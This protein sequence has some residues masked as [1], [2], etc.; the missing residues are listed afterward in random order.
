MLRRERGATAVLVAGSLFLLM[1]IAAIAIDYSAALNERRQDVGAAD[2]AAIGGLLEAAITTAAN[3][4]QVAV[5]EAKQIAN[6]NTPGTITN[7][8]WSACTDAEALVNPSTLGSLG[9]VNGTPCISFSADFTTMRVRIP[10]QDVPTTFGR[11]L[12]RNEITTFAA[13]EATLSSSLGGGG[14]FPSGLLSGSGTEFCI[15]ASTA[16]AGI[17]GSPASGNFGDFVP[18]FYTDVDPGPSDTTCTSGLTPAPL[19]WTMANGIDHF[20]GLAPAIDAGT[21]LNGSG[22]PALPRPLFPDRVEPGGGYSPAD[23]TNGLVTGGTFGGGHVGRLD[24]GPYQGG[25]FTI[26]DTITIDNRPLW[27]YIR[28]D[29][30]TPSCVAAR[31]LGASPA[32]WD[33]AKLTMIDCL[34]D[35]NSLLFTDQLADTPRL[36]SVPVYFQSSPVPNGFDYDIREF[37]P[38]FIQSIWSNHGPQW[39]CDEDVVVTDGESCRHDPGM[40]GQMRINAPG[41]QTIL[42]ASAFVLKCSHLPADVCQTTLSSGVPRNV[43]VSVELT[44]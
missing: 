16:G 32:D 26:F 9:I 8:D 35:H 17:C 3:P 37:A 15:K 23:I 36:A 25:G 39:T 29:V 40:R 13:A 43:F 12:G 31:A 33:A 11:V 14:G 18:Y 22:C 28:G 20:F 19:A 44:R 38:I 1:G 5:D 7:A 30:T 6:T 24:R 42:A 21:R 10:D 2:T 4:L 34:N 27:T 41:Q